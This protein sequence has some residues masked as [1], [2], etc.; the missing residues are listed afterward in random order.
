LERLERE[1]IVRKHQ[2]SKWAAS[3][4]PVLKDNG[5]VIV[6]GEYKVTANQAVIVDTHPIPRIEDI[7]ARIEDILAKMAG[8]TLYMKL[9]LSHAY[10]QLQ[11]D[12]AAK[13]YLV[14]NNQ[15]GLYEN[16]QLP[17]GV[18]SA[19]A[20]FQRTMESILQGLDQVA[21]YIDDIIGRSEKEHL[22]V[23][24]EVFRDSRKVE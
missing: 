11:L 9:E 6:C 7:F 3:I 13:E 16:T 2:F 24:D 20:M 21:V 18:S 15:R 19:P 22:K 5:A 17:F 14:I 12:D 4:V 1:G 8:G 23:L 10:L